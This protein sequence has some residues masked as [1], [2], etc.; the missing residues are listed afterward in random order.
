MYLGVVEVKRSSFGCTVSVDRH[1]LEHH[2]TVG[3]SVWEFGI[4]RRILSHGRI[5][6]SCAAS[7]GNFHVFRL[8]LRMRV[9]R[10]AD[11]LVRR[12]SLPSSQRSW[13]AVRDQ[14][15]NLGVRYAMSHQRALT[16][17]LSGSVKICGCSRCDTEEHRLNP[18]FNGGDKKYIVRVK[19]LQ[20][21][22]IV[23]PTRCGHKVRDACGAEGG[24]GLPHGKGVSESENTT[25]SD[26]LRKG[27]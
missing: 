26:R 20:V 18:I 2:N 4:R 1:S 16:D 11:L 24:H 23:A 10:L 8:L 19:Q 15:A 12:H 17:M 7:S 22:G 21:V 6:S 3:I 25:D 14:G 13:L 9:G 27:A 5:A